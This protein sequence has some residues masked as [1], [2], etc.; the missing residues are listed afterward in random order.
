MTMENTRVSTKG[1]IVLPKPV[2]ESHQW[3]CGQELIVIDLPDCVI[4]KARPVRDMSWKNIV[5]RLTKPGRPPA[6]EAEMQAAV[7]KK[8]TE[9]YQRSLKK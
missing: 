8:A 1:Q 7:R 3:D 9:R 4:L 5:G 6:T 2:R